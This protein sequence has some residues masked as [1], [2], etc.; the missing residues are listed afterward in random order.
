MEHCLHMHSK[1]ACPV[2][3]LSVLSF[4][5][6]CYLSSGASPSSLVLKCRSEHH[7]RPLRSSFPNRPLISNRSAGEICQSWSPAPPA[8][9]FNGRIVMSAV[10]ILVWVAY[11]LLICVHWLRSQGSLIRFDAFEYIIHL[12]MFLRLE[13]NENRWWSESARRLFDL[14]F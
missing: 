4:L 12:Q 14:F 10:S 1:T 5:V 2:I 9:H 11:W 3:Q 7:L 6:G 8:F 13:P